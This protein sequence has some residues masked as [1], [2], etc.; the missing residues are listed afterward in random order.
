[1][2]RHRQPGRIQVRASESSLPTACYEQVSIVKQKFRLQGASKLVGQR[3]KE[4]F[5]P[6]HLVHL[7]FVLLLAMWNNVSIEV[8]E[9]S[10]CQVSYVSS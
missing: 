6:I 5:Y 4:T 7:I 2:G 8:S 10:E 3:V 1:M 9:W